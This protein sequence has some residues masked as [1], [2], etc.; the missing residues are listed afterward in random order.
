MAGQVWT[1]S[2]TKVVLVDRADSVQVDAGG[3]PRECS[4]GL[5]YTLIV[6]DRKLAWR[7]CTNT[8]SDP[9]VRELTGEKVLADADFQSVIQSL[10]KVAPS[11]H[12]LCGADKSHRTLTITNP[13]GDETYLDDFYACEKRGTYASNMDGVFDV[14][15]PLAQ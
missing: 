13:A 14:V 12:T 6:A 3:A 1:T 15:L 9:T 5:T 7:V 8:P 4:S 10:E 2:S 11:S